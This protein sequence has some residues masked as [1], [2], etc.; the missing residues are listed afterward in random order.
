[1]LPRL[2]GLR[3]LHL[4]C[5]FG[6]DTLVLAGCGADVTGLDFSGPALAAAQPGAAGGTE[7]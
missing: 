2:A 4:Q 1:M 3:V 6:R 5:R 7:G